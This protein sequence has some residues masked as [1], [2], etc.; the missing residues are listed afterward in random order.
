MV[1]AGWLRLGTEIVLSTVELRRALIM[2]SPCK[3]L[4]VHWCVRFFTTHQTYGVTELRG[5]TGVTAPRHGCLVPEESPKVRCTSSPNTRPTHAVPLLHRYP[6]RWPPRTAR[7]GS[8]LDRAHTCWLWAHAS[9]PSALCATTKLPWPPLL[10]LPTAASLVACSRRIQPR[11]RRLS[12]LSR[13]SSHSCPQ[14]RDGAS[15]TAT[16]RPRVAHRHPHPRFRRRSAGSSLASA[17][18][19]PSDRVLGV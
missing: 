15:P 19:L 9:L 2:D 10:Q 16:T 5:V 8:A 3:V 12:R 13:L 6:P 11:S 4:Y 1:A 17:D 14:M 7:R 18:R